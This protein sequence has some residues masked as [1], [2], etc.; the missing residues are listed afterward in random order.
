MGA[1]A[2]NDI[3]REKIAMKVEDRDSLNCPQER[4]CDSS[5]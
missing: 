2:V 1:L 4:H 5:F 3:A